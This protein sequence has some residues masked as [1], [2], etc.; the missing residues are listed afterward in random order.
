MRK[1]MVV[2]LL[3]FSLTG[4]IGASQSF[5]KDKADEQ[6]KNELKNTARTAYKST[7]SIMTNKDYG[8]VSRGIIDE[9]T[10][11]M[12]LY[13]IGEKKH[14]LLVRLKAGYDDDNHI[15]SRETE[16]K[17]RN[18][19]NISAHYKAQA[20]DIFMAD[21]VEIGGQVSSNLIKQKRAQAKI[22]QII[23]EILDYSSKNRNY[24]PIQL[25]VYRSQDVD[26]FTKDIQRLYGRTENERGLTG[27]FSGP[28]FWDRIH[29]GW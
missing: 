7:H 28:R 10:M 27:L 15:G 1:I 4:I 21:G 9:R 29:I 14:V 13:L 18:D 2:F 6:I 8:Y 16:Y 12:L 24:K 5:Y 23:R 17:S 11:K 22:R 20:I 19:V 26:Y 25:I 3:I